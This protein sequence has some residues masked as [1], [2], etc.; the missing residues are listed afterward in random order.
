[1]DDKNLRISKMNKKNYPEPDIPADEAWAEMKQMLS[2]SPGHTHPGKTGSLSPR[3]IFLYAGPGLLIVSL[4][5]YFLIKQ[6]AETQPTATIHYSQDKPL[7]DSLSD[8]TVVFLDR[9]STVSEVKGTNKEKLITIKGAA[10]FQNITSDNHAPTRLRVGSLDVLPT[11]A[12]VYLSFDTVL[13]VSFVHVQSGTAVVDANG[14]KLTLTAGEAVQYD[15]KTKHVKNRQ[16][17]NANLF[18]YAT[19]VFEFNDTPLQVAAESIEKAYGVSVVIENKKLYNCR[20]TTRFDNKSLKEVLD[21]MAYTLNFE[22]HL[23]EKNKFVLITG[24]GCE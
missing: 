23:D 17:A 10:Y 20:I 24:K 16:Q 19:M 15:E 12:E 8:G 5:A 7:K 4:V 2:V 3:N 11:N 18:S 21:I 1:M 6:K 14:E 9:K 22:Y 13:L